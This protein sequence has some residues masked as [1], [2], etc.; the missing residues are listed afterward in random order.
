MQEIRIRSAAHSSI[1]LQ[2][3]QPFI[4]AAQARSLI[5]SRALRNSAVG[6]RQIVLYADTKGSQC[7]PSLT[8]DSTASDQLA[9]AIY[10]C[11]VCAFRGLSPRKGWLE[12]RAFSAS[13]DARRAASDASTTHF[14]VRLAFAPPRPTPPGPVRDQGHR[15]GRDN[16][17]A[18]LTQ[19]FSSRF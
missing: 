11:S 5:C 18:A 13:A 10:V 9:V 14:R 6:L 2:E 12:T 1:S 17:V 7:F 19:R 3:G 4:H 16:Y 8:D 15:D